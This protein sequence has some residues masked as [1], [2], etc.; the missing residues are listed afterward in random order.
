MVARI[1]ASDKQRQRAKRLVVVFTADLSQACACIP[2]CLQMVAQGIDALVGCAGKFASV[3]E[4]QAFLAAH[5]KHDG[6]KGK[7]EKKDK[8]KKKGKHKRDK[9]QKQK[10]K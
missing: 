3:E 5:A 6:K 10:S 1:L 4:A 8:D 7:K 2:V 9:S